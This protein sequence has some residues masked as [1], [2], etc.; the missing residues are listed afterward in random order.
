MYRAEINSRLS[1]C[2]L[3]LRFRAVMCSK[4]LVNLYWQCP[5]AMN[6]MGINCTGKLSI[7]PS[8]I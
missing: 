7:G 1:D 2:A 5:L 4:V 8:A 3:M 6:T